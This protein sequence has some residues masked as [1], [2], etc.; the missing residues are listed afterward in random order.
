MA[1]MARRAMRRIDATQLRAMGEVEGWIT[2]DEA[3]DGADVHTG[4]H[5]T[6]GPRMW[7]FAQTFV[8]FAP[9][10]KSGREPMQLHA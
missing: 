2:W 5:P 8:V 3:T 1:L 9:T 6:G 4:D 10:Q 7:C